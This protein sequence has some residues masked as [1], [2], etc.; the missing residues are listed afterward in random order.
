MCWED[1][2]EKV[3]W[4]VEGS[5]RVCESGAD[6]GYPPISRVVGGVGGGGYCLGLAVSP[7]RRAGLEGLN[8]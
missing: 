4:N 1:E 8:S 3:L 5:G 6:R 7:R 2:K